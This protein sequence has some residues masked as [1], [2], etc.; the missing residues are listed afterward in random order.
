MSNPIWAN[1]KVVVAVGTGG[2]G[3]TTV[4]AAM[5]IAAAAEG[6]RALV[7][8]ID[9]ARRLA[10]A[11]GLP[12]FGNVEH[13][14]EPEALERYGVHLKAPLWAMMPDVK[15]TFDELIERFAPSDEKKRAIIDNRIYQ[16]FST[17]L[18][19]SHEY[20]AVEKLHEV[21]TS[22]RYDLIILDTPP[23]GNAVD[24]LDAPN[25]IIDFLE[26]DTVQWLVRP[27]ALAG[28]FSLKI[29]DIGS[30]FITKTIGKLA[31]ADTLRELAEFVLAFQGMYDGFRERS[32]KVKELLASEEVAFVLVS[33]TQ[34]TQNDAMFRFKEELAAEGLKT[35][36]LIVNR[37]RHAPHEAF[38]AKALEALVKRT[39]PLGTEAQRQSA[40]ALIEETTLARGDEE[41]VV[42]LTQQLGGLRTLALPELPS[43]L[44]DLAS[45]AALQRH[46]A[47]T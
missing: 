6:K 10:N 7:M 29:L 18:A 34:R 31:G 36:A 41:S 28:K 25:R 1:R 38:G 11:L 44:H 32:R 14:I 33:S 8:T 3:K 27:Y 37:V 21:Y 5:A 22:G 42:R 4:S 2:V 39:A 13:R 43:D 46:F 20:A 26:Q 15:R 35:R 23:S 19:G 30:S 17:A 45:L 47:A 16:H 9:P 12:A 40:E 24:F